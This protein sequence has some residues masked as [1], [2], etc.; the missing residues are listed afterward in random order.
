M[1][2]L[3]AKDSSAAAEENVAFS[4]PNANEIC[5]TPTTNKNIDNKNIVFFITHTPF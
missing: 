3:I 4:G 1:S 2:P 5:T